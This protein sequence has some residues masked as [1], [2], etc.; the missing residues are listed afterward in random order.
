MPYYELAE[1]NALAL[2]LKKLSKGLY[3]KKIKLVDENDEETAE[4][5]KTV[6]DKVETIVWANA[7]LEVNQ[8]LQIQIISINSFLLFFLLFNIRNELLMLN[9]EANTFTLVHYH[10]SDS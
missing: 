10:I 9:E 5:Y 7:L 3:I 6:F 4:E 2:D 8:S 1:T